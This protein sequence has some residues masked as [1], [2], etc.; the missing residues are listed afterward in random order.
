M[1][2]L[3]NIFNEPN[4]LPLYH[5]LQNKISL[6]MYKHINDLLPEV[7]NKLTNNQIHAHFIRQHHF[8]IPA[9]EHT[10][11]HAKK[12]EIYQSPYMECAINKNYC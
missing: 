4:I 11:V 5:I 6:M 9:K 8:F 3:R 12:F 7:M 10:N 2:Y 1:T